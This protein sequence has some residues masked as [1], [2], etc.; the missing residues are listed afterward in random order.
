LVETINVF[1]IGDTGLVELDSIRPGPRDVD[2]AKQ[3]LLILAPVLDDVIANPEIASEIAREALREQVNNVEVS[4][5]GLAVRQVNDFGRRSI[6]NFVGELLR[7]AYV[8]ARAVLRATKVE[9]G[10]A[11]KGVREGAYR[12]V[13]A[14][15]VGGA[16]TDLTSVTHFAGIFINF[17]T[18]HA[19]ILTDY[20]TTTF[21]NPTLVEIINWIVRLGSPARQSVRRGCLHL[22]QSIASRRCLGLDGGVVCPIASQIEPRSSEAAKAKFGSPYRMGYG[23]P[24]AL[25]VP[26]ATVHGSKRVTRDER[27]E[28]R[29]TPC[30]SGGS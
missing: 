19:E 20:V 15:L 4:G 26:D 17:V 3:E 22:K 25:K 21:Q 23:D 9:T 1:V 16:A 8:P 28:G 18:R 29:S 14:A 12:A 6:Q 7:R 27:R 24:E 11:W 30:P 2:A 5:D 13:G 10:V